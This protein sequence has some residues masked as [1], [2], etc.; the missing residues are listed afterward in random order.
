MK[1]CCF[2]SVIL[3]FFS[4]SFAQAEEWTIE[5]EIE[6]EAPT[7]TIEI[8]EDTT[9]SGKK[10][11]NDK[12][13]VVNEDVTL[14]LKPGT[15]IVMKNGT[16]LIIKGKLIGIGEEKKM[17]RFYGEK[18]EEASHNTNYSI[19]TTFKS[20]LE[21][22]HFILE[23]G[24]GN[25]GIATMPALNIKGKAR[26]TNG[27]IR[28]NLV[29]AVRGWDENV[30]ISSCEIY[31]NDYLAL[32]HKGKGEIK[33]QNNWWGS[34]D[35]P[36][37]NNDGEMI[38]GEVAYEPWDKKGPIPVILV[39][40]FGGSVGFKLLREKAKDKWWFNPVNSLGPHYIIKALILAGYE[41]EENLIWSHYDWRKNCSDN[42]KNYF[43]KDI[44]TAKKLTGHRQVHIVAY[45]LGGLISRTYVQSDDFE[46]DIDKLITV[47]TPHLGT[48]DAYL[49]WAGGELPL[50]WKPVLPY[51]WYLQVLDQEIKTTETLRKILPSVGEILPIYTYLIN[52]ENDKPIEYKTQHER[53]MF[54]EELSWNRKKL[55]RKT[56][57]T[58][59]AGTGEKT[60]D[61]IKVVPYLGFSNK[62]KDGMPEPYL[63]SKNSKRGD[64]R[65]LS[66][67]ATG[68]NNLTEDIVV[69]EGE[70][71][72]ILQITERTILDRLNVTPKHPWIFE[73]L[74]HFL[75]TQKGPADVEIT[76]DD[77][78]LA[79]IPNSNY[80]EDNN[81]EKLVY[82]SFPFK[83]EDIKVTFT[84]N[85][86][87]KVNTAFWLNNEELSMK[88]GEF[89]IE[90]DVKIEYLLGFNDNKINVNEINWSNILQIKSPQSKQYL[91]WQYLSPE[92]VLW[93]DMESIPQFNYLIDSEP[94]KGILDLGKMELGN[95]KLEVE[96][97]WMNNLKE[98]SEKGEVEFEVISSYKSLMVLIDRMYKEEEITDWG[99]RSETINLIAEAY[100][101]S[102][103][104]DN[105]TL[106]KLAEAKLEANNDKIKNDSRRYLLE[107][108]EYLENT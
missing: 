74:H 18:Y 5:I 102:K 73:T 87:G 22:E 63:P 77:K 81:G 91:N 85:K 40:G 101:Y 75:L 4:F 33:A 62:W 93:K 64:G 37:Y 6:E 41:P 24:G 86:G 9:W 58:V 32:E 39:P 10:I 65:V 79:E 94:V 31:E 59:I 20:E 99:L 107:S 53:N 66:K 67:S 52:T 100:E 19:N 108:I 97:R 49:A 11:F 26:L 47:G 8:T 44:D 23:N 43:K 76:M 48:S 84:G 78:E 51:L 29:T 92:A 57:L 82:A 15:L 36:S 38:K 104:G 71:S 96:A 25:Q 55:Q 28:R 95:H 88:E 80:L 46:D 70:H 61:K 17:I 89:N 34:D 35:G 27:I 56:K 14:T 60:L 54:L 83:K 7:R 12:K 68:S 30:E 45:S 98:N 16:E 13:V 3:L 90:K 1:F 2:F 103:K 105:K 72:E 69:V 42:V 106:S 21:L 50:E